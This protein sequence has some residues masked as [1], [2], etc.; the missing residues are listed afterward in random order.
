MKTSVAS[1]S[2]INYFQVRRNNDKRRYRLRY[3]A[4]A[5]GARRRFINLIITVSAY[6]SFSLAY[7][8]IRIPPE[9][10]LYIL[11]NRLV[12]FKL[13]RKA[14]AIVFYG[15]SMYTKHGLSAR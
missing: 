12:N 5:N 7:L 10:T 13:Q 3:L 9:I 1:I 2:C 14:R 15:K 11:R 4:V 8:S 6:V